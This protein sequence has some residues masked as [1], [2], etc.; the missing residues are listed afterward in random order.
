M[1]E[2]F[3][4]RC[5]VT[6]PGWNNHCGDLWRDHVL[7]TTGRDICDIVG[8]SPRRAGDW[9]AVMRR[10]GASSMSA[11]V[12]AVHG[13]SVQPRQ[14]GRGYLV[15]RGWALGV[16]RGSHAEFYGGACISM[17]DVDE[18]WPI[19]LG[20]DG[21]AGFHEAQQF[22]GRPVSQF[23]RHRQPLHHG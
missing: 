16:C 13:V 6:D 9:A 18:A 7:A 14:A 12:S 11:V 23:D 2:G 3:A 19:E 10:V 22:T 1:G 17:S 5:P 21:H 20:R 15:R 4:E 8:P